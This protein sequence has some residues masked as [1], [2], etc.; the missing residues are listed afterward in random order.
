M[1]IL[2]TLTGSLYRKSASSC[3]EKSRIGLSGST[4]PDSVNAL[5]AQPPFLYPGIV[6][7]PSAS[8]LESS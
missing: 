8:D 5:T 1:S 6:I 7:A 2:L 3:S 4:N